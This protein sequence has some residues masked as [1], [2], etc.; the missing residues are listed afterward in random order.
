[1]A[2]QYPCTKVKKRNVSI[3][4]ITASGELLTLTWG[5]RTDPEPTKTS[6]NLS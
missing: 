5:F 2:A 6:E 1:M 3:S 4:L